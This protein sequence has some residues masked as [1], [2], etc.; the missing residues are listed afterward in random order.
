MKF[1]DS[2]KQDDFDTSKLLT[3]RKQCT[4]W[5]RTKVMQ[6]RFLVIRIKSAVLKGETNQFQTNIAIHTLHCPCHSHAIYL[7]CVWPFSPLVLQAWKCLARCT[8]QNATL[9]VDRM[10]VWNTW[11]GRVSAA[12]PTK[13]WLTLDLT[14]AEMTRPDTFTNVV[15]FFCNCAS[16]CIADYATTP[17]WSLWYGKRYSY[18]KAVLT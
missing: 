5:L 8:T 4:T 11:T 16:Q 14:V 17:S 12:L 7:P 1:F 13:S 3:T 2:S 18:D 15:K 9:E 10:V 6:M